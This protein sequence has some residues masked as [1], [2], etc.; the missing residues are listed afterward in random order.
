MLVEA[1]DVFLRDMGVPC[2]ATGGYTFTGLFD[3]P[4]EQLSAVGV[5]FLSTMYQVTAKTSDVAAAA[6][7]SNSPLTVNGTAYVVRDVVQV[8]DGAFTYLTLS[9]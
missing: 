1:L 5:N 8:D 9:K 7:A 4:D 3:Q 6:L 2:V